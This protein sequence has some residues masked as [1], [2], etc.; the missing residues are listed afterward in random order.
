[1]FIL[2]LSEIGK[3]NEL[4]YM[5]TD[6]FRTRYYVFAKD[7]GSSTSWGFFSCCTQR[8]E[9]SHAIASE[10]AVVYLA[11]TEYSR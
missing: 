5:L 7:E 11:L 1:M 9:I 6:S 3:V 10:V 8:S 2:R 4:T